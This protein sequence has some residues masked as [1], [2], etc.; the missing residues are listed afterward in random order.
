MPSLASGKSCCTAWASTCAAEWRITARPSSVSAG[1]GAT[2]TSS[3]GAQ[4]RSLSTPSGARTTITASCPCERQP[5]VADGLAGGRARRHPDAV[6]DGGTGRGG[7]GHGGLSETSTVVRRAYRAPA[8]TV[9]AR[10]ERGVPR[11]TTASRKAAIA[12]TA[13]SVR[14]VGSEVEAV[15]G[16][17]ELGVHHR[18]L[19]TPPAAG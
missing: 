10:P 1:T 19:A 11:P 8:T 13:A 9:S 5:G 4:A 2:S 15:L 18:R 16:V 6:G 7:R 3:S 14:G 12:R 17:G